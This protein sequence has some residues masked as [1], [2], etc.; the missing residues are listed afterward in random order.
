MFPVCFI[1]CDFVATQ[2]HRPLYNAKDDAS[3]RPP[4]HA[5]RYVNLDTAQTMRAAFPSEFSID[6]N[7]RVT[8]L[9]HL[10]DAD[11]IAVGFGGGGVCVA[12]VRDNAVVLC[13]WLVGGSVSHVVYQALSD[14]TLAFLWI[15]T[16]LSADDE[17]HDEDAD[18]DE[19]RVT[20]TMFQ[21]TYASI[22]DERS[23]SSNDDNNDD[24]DDDDD[25]DDT[26]HIRNRLA[27]PRA[28]SQRYQRRLPRSTR[29]MT[30]AVLSPE[31][32]AAPSLATVC[33]SLFFSLASLS[34]SLSL[35]F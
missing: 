28:A 8:S 27:Q 22:G 6:N 35:P 4:P 23:E 11:A 7:R 25:D 13:E 9:Q 15:A 32:P 1:A 34:L 16:E 31:P 26:P 24:D 20:L 21:L 19:G 30:A 29:L 17:E 14:D 18:D 10:S 5:L 3:R 12:G 2:Q 33:W